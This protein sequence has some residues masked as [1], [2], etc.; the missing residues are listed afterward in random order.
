MGK[1]LFFIYQLYPLYSHY[2]AVTV[3][4][5]LVP[6]DYIYLVPID[7]LHKRPHIDM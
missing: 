4:I 6:I 5:Y 3:N 1:E 2:L 7:F